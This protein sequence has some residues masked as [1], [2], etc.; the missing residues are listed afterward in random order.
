MSNRPLGRKRC[1]LITSCYDYSSFE[2][3]QFHGQ[4]GCSSAGRAPALK[5]EVS[6]SNSSSPPS[7]AHSSALRT[8]TDKNEDQ[9]LES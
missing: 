7:W 2:E 9:W 1:S 6:D 8:H 4:Y 5:Q 3:S